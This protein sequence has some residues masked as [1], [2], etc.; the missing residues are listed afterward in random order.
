M[1]GPG[2]ARRT[3]AAGINAGEA[4]RLA[5]PRSEEIPPSIRVL[6]DSS[7]AQIS[8]AVG[9]AYPNEIIR[10]T[11]PVFETGIGTVRWR[12]VPWVTNEHR[13]FLAPAADA[14]AEAAAR[15]IGKSIDDLTYKLGYS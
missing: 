7:A 13:P 12:R 8:S 15:E 5:A 9:P 11:H 2:V 3:G 14:K 6:A 10:V 4:Q 1:A